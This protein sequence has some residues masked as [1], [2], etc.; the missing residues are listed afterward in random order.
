MEI[1]RCKKRLSVL[2]FSGTAFIIFIL[3]LQTIFGRYGNKSD[4]VWKW[5]LP[6]IMPT[7]SLI[8]SVLITDINANKSIK[9]KTVDTFYY[10]ISFAT[11]ATYLIIVSLT[12]LLQ[13]FSSFPP[14]ELIRHSNLWLGP[15]QGIVSGLIGAFFVKSIKQ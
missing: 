2:W 7:L 6:T 11:S 8:V 9:T 12:I 4:E 13:P 10:R 15:L 14:L 5:L 3:I 1:E